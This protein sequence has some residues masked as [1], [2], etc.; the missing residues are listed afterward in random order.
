MP[1]P[2]ST[3]QTVPAI[4]RWLGLWTR[5]ASAT[6]KVVFISE[7][8]GGGFGSKITS[9]ISLIIPAMLSKKTGAPVMMRISREEEHYIGRARPSLIGRIKVG[10]RQGRQDHRAR[11]VRDSGQRPVRS[12]GRRG[13]ERAHGFAAVP[14]AGHALARDRGADQHSSARFAKPARR[15][16]GHRAH[17][18]DPGQSGAETG[19]SI[20]WRSAGSTRRKARRTSGRQLPNGQAGLLHQRVHQRSAGSAAHE[21]FKWDERKCAAQAQRHQGARHRS[22]DA[23]A[24]VGGSVGFDGLFVIKPDGQAVLPVR[25]RQSGHGIGAAMCIASRRKSSACRGRSAKSPGAIPRRI[26]R[27][28]A[29]RAAARPPTP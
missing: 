7:Y 17:G 2:Q 3:A 26:F 8:T 21:T 20:R 4:A 6:S 11:H 5:R 28:P 15:I 12:A 13:I 9:A 27:G 14:A 29:H 18:A 22:G 10:I 1:A 25:H 16:A 19:R 24:F 23:V